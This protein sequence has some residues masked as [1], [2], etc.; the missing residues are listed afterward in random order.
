MEAIAIIISVSFGLFLIWSGYQLVS[1]YGSSYNNEPL[2]E[3]IQP[4]NEINHIDNSNSLSKRIGDERF[5]TTT[6][7]YWEDLM[8][9]SCTYN[10]IKFK[11]IKNNTVHEIHKEHKF[12]KDLVDL[13]CNNNLFE[14][15]CIQACTDNGINTHWVISKRQLVES[16]V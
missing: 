16:L 2:L 12:F 1:M 9:T 4:V 10:G 5:N 15:D 7:P 13:I 8:L 11:D 3:D 6:F 14:G